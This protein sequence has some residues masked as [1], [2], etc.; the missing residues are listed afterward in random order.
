MKTELEMTKEELIEF[1]KTQSNE[2]I[3]HVQFEM[4][5]DKNAKECI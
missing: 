1:I 5:D 4:E 3:I 2:F